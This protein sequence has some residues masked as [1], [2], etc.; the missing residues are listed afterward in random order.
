[1]MPGTYRRD[2]SISA[3]EVSLVAA[4]AR[5]RVIGQHGKIPWRIPGEQKIFKR[6]TVGRALILGRKTFDSIGRALPDRSTIVV[7]RQASFS[8]PQVRVAHGVE[9]ALEIA[10]ALKLDA[11]V[12]G[13]AEIYAQT[14]DIAD[15][16]YLSIVHAEFEGD[17]FFPELPSG[18]FKLASAEE[19]QAT[20][21]YTLATYERIV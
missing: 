3:M 21:P 6:L 13:G 16:I 1:M 9:E 19:F 10:R 15:R 12:G 20:I 18:R 17:A 8:A 2:G 7:T 14:L 4:M 11:A 5:N